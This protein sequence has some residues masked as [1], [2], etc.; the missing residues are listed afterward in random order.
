LPEEGVDDKRL[1]VGDGQDLN[2]LWEF[3]RFQP[4][5]N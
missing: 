4:R 1:F 5:R 3:I 2:I